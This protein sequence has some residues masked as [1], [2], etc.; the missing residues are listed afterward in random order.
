MQSSAVVTLR[1]LVMLLC[2]V[3]VPL[4][5]I[6][7]SSLPRVFDSLVT[8][9]GLPRFARENPATNEARDRGGDAPI[10]SATPPVAPAAEVSQARGAI[11]GGGSL[12]APGVFS[13]SAATGAAIDRRQVPPMH[14]QTAHFDPGAS[15]PPGMPAVAPGAARPG[16]A[17][18][19]QIERRLRELGATYYL[20]ETWGNA[21]QMYRFHC[22]V[23][24]AGDPGQIRHFDATEAD[25][26]SAMGHVL[27]DVE[28]YR[29]AV[30]H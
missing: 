8:G 29:A 26:L 27:E 10:F 2:L 12:W 16:G 6:F 11:P 17:E 21:G 30:V 22:K 7:G 18:F 9:R 20:L 24:A 25:P 28:K 14:E 15:A 4:A 1:A 13:G 5:A 23:A 3:L 19:Q